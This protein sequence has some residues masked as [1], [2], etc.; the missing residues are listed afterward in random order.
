MNKHNDI[1]LLPSVKNT[2]TLRLLNSTLCGCEFELKNE[3]TIFI[4]ASTK[5]L[6][7]YNLITEN[8]FIIPVEE[9]GMN[10]D[11]INTSIPKFSISLRQFTDSGYSYRSLQLNKVI[12]IGSL[13]IA[14]KLSSSE[15]GMDFNLPN[16]TP[17]IKKTNIRKKINLAFFTFFLA[18]VS[19][20]YFKGGFAA[21]MN[22]D[23]FNSNANLITSRPSFEV[24]V[25]LSKNTHNTEIV[26]Y[27]KTVMADLIERDLVALA[28][29]FI[30]TD[31]NKNIKFAVSGSIGD[32]ALQQI[33]LINIKAYKN[34]IYLSIDLQDDLLSGSSYLYG[35]NSYIK[36]SSNHWLVKNL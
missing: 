19:L 33:K 2:L 17:K 28:V 18:L 15:W 9:N 16:E 10:F 4:V 31:N 8:S 34:G 20:S 5:E 36:L 27:P 23:I 3:T 13:K 21:V 29:P 6:E 26:K 30:R 32:E 12:Y 24:P 1:S 35:Q 11:I 25:T 22:K 14:L 7:H